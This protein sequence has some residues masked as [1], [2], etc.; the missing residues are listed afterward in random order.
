MPGQISFLKKVTKA[1]LC[2]ISSIFKIL[3]LLINKKLLPVMIEKYLNKSFDLF[4]K[5]YHKNI[6]YYIKLKIN[7]LL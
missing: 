2:Q 5:I 1:K 3:W 4:Y 7:I 6:K